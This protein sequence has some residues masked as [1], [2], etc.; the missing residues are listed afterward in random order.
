MYG[1]FSFL[2]DGNGNI[3]YIGCDERRRI[4]A[5]ESSVSADD[6]ECIAIHN[7]GSRE[8]ADLY[9]YWYYDPFT[10]NLTLKRENTTNDR[11][12][13]D[14]EKII[15][16]VHECVPEFILK[17]V[18]NPFT[19]GQFEGQVTPE[20][21]ELLHG[22]ESVI[23]TI[24]DSLSDIAYETIISTVHETMNDQILS[25]IWDK[26]K[27]ETDESD[28]CYCYESVF[29]AVL[30]YLS[31]FFVFKKWTNSEENSNINPYQPCISLWEM[32][33]VPVFNGRQ[34]SLH[35]SKGIFYTENL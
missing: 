7:F 9:N 23:D 11:N 17:P 15:A 21:L 6:D 20:I 18:I 19:N 13:L 2:S 3:F 28:F 30:G 34:W 1:F 32:G 5:G 22:W 4:F 31:S 25:I 26:I 27:A 16:A 14:K 29:E 12:L 8:K 33:I 35:G 10:D 24:D